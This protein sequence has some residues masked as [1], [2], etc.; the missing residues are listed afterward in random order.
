MKKFVAYRVSSAILFASIALATVV[1]VSN[2]ESND[3][4]KFV[5]IHALADPPPQGLEEYLKE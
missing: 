4:G 5:E 1:W 2:Y 3:M